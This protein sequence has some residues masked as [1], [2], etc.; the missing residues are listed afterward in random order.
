MAQTS[1]NIRQI[2]I[3]VIGAFVR[4]LYALRISLCRRAYAIIGRYRYDYILYIMYSDDMHVRASVY[5]C[6]IYT[7][8]N[9]CVVIT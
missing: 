5:R 2:D 7:Y 8:V 4:C 9:A 6:N 3:I 1:S